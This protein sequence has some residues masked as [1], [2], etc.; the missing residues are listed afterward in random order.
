MRY[1]L[2]TGEP[3][4]T[5]FMRTRPSST[6]WAVVLRRALYF[7]QF[8][9]PA[10][11]GDR[12]RRG[13]LSARERLPRPADDSATVYYIG[14]GTFL[15]CVAILL[16]G[17]RIER[18]LE[19]LNWI[20]VAASSVG[21]LVLALCSSRRR[22]GWRPSSDFTGFDLARGQ[23]RSSSRRAPTSFCSARSSA[24]SGAGG[25]ANIMLANWA[26]DKATGWAGAPA[27]SRRP[28]AAARSISPTAASRSPGREAMRRW[29]G[30]WRIVA[31][32]QWG[33]FFI[34]AMLGM[35]LPALLYVTF[36]PRGT[37]IQGLGI[38]AALA[39]A[40]GAQ[41]PPR[42]AVI[43]A[44]PGRVDP[45]QDAA[46][47]LEGMVRAITDM[48]WTGS[49]RVRGWRGGDVR[50]VYYGVLVV[51]VLGRIALKLAQPFLLLQM[52]RTWRGWCS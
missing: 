42:S 2:A 17:R 43:V 47:Q 7:L 8:G 22:R 6:F 16:L 9:W 20:L 38:S 12:G 15:A 52:R 46:R 14:V 35:V 3:V 24:Y 33:V 29:H 1:T 37:D 40:I 31:S 28:S 27:T 45:V 32:D 51:G 41:R 21:F 50:A 11:A 44:F 25:V 34:G 26:R 49:R 48:L 39:P 18:T 23:F 10:C 36:L 13:L 4:F 19:I 30:W 5:G